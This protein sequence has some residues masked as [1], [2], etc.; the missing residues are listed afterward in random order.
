M[1]GSVKD[2]KG[3]LSSLLKNGNFIA[4]HRILLSYNNDTLHIL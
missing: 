3:G 1:R 4:Q 2:T